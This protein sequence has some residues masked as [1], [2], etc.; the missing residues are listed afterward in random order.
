MVGTPCGI[1]NGSAYSD[2]VLSN[3]H[4]QD[5]LAMSID[6]FYIFLLLTTLDVVP[7]KISAKEALEYYYNTV[8][9]AKTPEE[10]QPASR[11][12]GH[13]NSGGGSS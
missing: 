10:L 13:S 4:L 5:K 12:E 9:L 2:F 6:N 3:V 8:K 7:Q 11:T 1:I